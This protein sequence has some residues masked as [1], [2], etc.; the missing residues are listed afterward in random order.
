MIGAPYF[1][2]TVWALVVRWF[3]PAT[4]RKI[5]VVPAGKVKSVLGEFVEIENLPVRFGGEL[6]WRFGGSP[7]LDRELAGIVGK[8]GEGWVEGP[9]R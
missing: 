3:D 5:V 1:F 8:L 7:M 2:P 6:D 4:T 9:I